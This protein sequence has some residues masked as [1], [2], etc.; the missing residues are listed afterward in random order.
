VSRTPFSPVHAGPASKPSLE[1]M[2]EDSGRGNPGTTCLRGP[3][4]KSKGREERPSE[5]TLSTRFMSGKNISE[6]G[7]GKRLV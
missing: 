7:K 2:G 4:G 5:F 3:G 1:E 6:R